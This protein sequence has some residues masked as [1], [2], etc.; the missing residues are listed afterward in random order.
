MNFQIQ[1]LC[2][3]IIMSFIT[4]FLFTVNIKAQTENSNEE[5]KEFK[6]WKIPNVS[7]G[8]EF[9][10]SPDGKSMIGNAKFEGDSSHQ[11]YTMKIDGT[12][13]KKINGIGEDACS[14]YFPDGQ[15]LIWTSTRDNLDLLKGDWSNAKEYPTGAELYTSDLDGG[16][17]VRLTSNKYYDAEVSV[18]PDGKKILF[19]RQ[20]DGKC[21]LWV[22]NA[23]GTDEHQVTFTE[24]WQEGGSFYL[25]D[26]ET[27][28]Y[29]AWLR[30]D[31]GKRGTPM[32]IFT[33]K[34]DGTDLKQIT[35][36]EGTNWA[37]HPAPDG[38][39][40]AFIRIL[41]PFN[42]EIYLMSIKTGEQT[43]LTY[44]DAFDGFPVISP[45]GKLL[46]FSSN[47][48]EAKGVRKLSPYLMD[49]SSLNL[50]PKE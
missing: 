13:I 11:V 5:G 45:D 8:A 28:I 23:D 39:H 48:D 22:M 16:N 27:I 30:K 12:N 40:F 18:S 49:I 7:N 35:F 20:I 50:D 15:K 36:D 31:D 32:T 3:V 34:D 43:R 14:Y 29:R 38:D 42:F 17:V 46:A 9:Y 37:P 1:R 4:A 41:P 2:L 21:D 6:V 33:I 24:E 44:N 25:N 19:T 10:F 47:R 26:N